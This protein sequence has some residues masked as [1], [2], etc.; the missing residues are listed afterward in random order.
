MDS[1]DQNAVFIGNDVHD[2]QVGDTIDFGDISATVS[3]SLPPGT[4]YLDPWTG[5]QILD[6]AILLVSTYERFSAAVPSDVWQEEALGRAVLFDAPDTLVTSFVKAAASTGGLGLVPRSLES[7]VADVYRAQVER[8]AMFLIFFAALLAVLG[9]TL[10]LALDSLM[11]GNVRRH[12]IERLYGATLRHL[13]WR[14]NLFVLMTFSLPVLLIFG[15]FALIADSIANI[16]PAVVAIVIA[17]Q[18]AM[19]TRAIVQLRRSSIVDQLRKD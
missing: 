18:C 5:H 10:V 2:Y 6:D 4:S 13:L 19:S 12:S 3:G 14:S 17:T 9:V 1:A 15:G 8:N 11:S 7:R 16:Y